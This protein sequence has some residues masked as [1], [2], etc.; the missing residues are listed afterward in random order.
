MPRAVF[1]FTGQGLGV[2]AAPTDFAVKHTPR[3]S[4]GWWL[5]SIGNI[6]RTE[7]ALH[8]YIGLLAARVE[9]K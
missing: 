6:G 1:I 2:I 8:E 4:R 9:K 5:P 7:S 3:R